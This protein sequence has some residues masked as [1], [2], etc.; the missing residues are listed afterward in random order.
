MR[1]VADTHERQS[2]AGA[3]TARAFA[4]RDLLAWREPYLL[5]L[6]LLLASRLWLWLALKFASEDAYITYR[7]ARNLASGLGLV[8]NPGEKVM[9]FTSPLWTV[10]NALGWKLTGDP[11]NWSRGWSVVADVV[12]LVVVA[13]LLRERV[14]RASAWV[15][16]FLFA[17]WTSFAAVAASGMENSAMLALVALGAMLV[18]RGSVAAGPALGALALMRPEGVFAAAVLALG[19][20]WRDRLVALAIAAAGFGAL[21]LYFGTIVPQSLTAKAELYGSPGPWAGRHWWEWAVPFSLGRWPV[22]LEARYV[23]LTTLL[24]APAAY[25]GAQRLWKLRR[26][27]LA[28]LAG[29]LLVVWAGYAAVGVAYFFWYLELPLACWFLLVAA[30]FPDLVRHRAVYASAVLFVF[31]T[32]T[33]VWELYTGRARLELAFAKVAEHLLERSRPADRVLLE[34]IGLVGYYSNAVIL[35]EVGLVSPRIAKRRM[36]GPG[37]ASDVIGA[38]QPEWIVMRR[39]VLTSLQAFAGRGAPFRSSAERD[40]VLAPY[41]ADTVVPGEDEGGALVVMRRAR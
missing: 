34:P 15:F 3:D 8:F 14:S 16:A 1:R 9:G 35:D 18:G 40:S 10:W 25:V 6:A 36:G 12:T 31:G 4:P 28:L 19:A 22:V 33:V 7:Y 5:P 17:A 38:E 29:A 20:R 11:A 21:W 30:G 39:G 24:G 27:D 26:T 41:R 13:G 23:F 37:W 2:A 32:W